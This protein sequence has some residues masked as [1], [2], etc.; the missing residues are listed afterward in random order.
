MCGVTETVCEA[1]AG[2][3]TDIGETAET[4]A[5]DAAETEALAGAPA[6]RGAADAAGDTNTGETDTPDT[7]AVRGPDEVERGVV[8]AERLSRESLCG[9]GA[10]GCCSSI[11]IG[12]C[13]CA[14]VCAP[15]LATDRPL[16]E[17]VCVCDGAR[18][19]ENAGMV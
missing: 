11:C 14:C 3:S 19:C 13:A 16:C 7:G 6:E 5:G 10:P 12:A 2:D 15:T 1:D 17:C 9:M 18:P 8:G 4:E